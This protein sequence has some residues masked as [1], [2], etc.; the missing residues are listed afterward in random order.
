MLLFNGSLVNSLDGEGNTALHTA[1]SMDCPCLTKLLLDHGADPEV[2]SQLGVKARSL[3]G[4]NTAS[5][6]EERPLSAEKLSTE[7]AFLEASK[8]VQKT[9][10]FIHLIRDYSRLYIHGTLT[11]YSILSLVRTRSIRNSG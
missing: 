7:K 11:N 2:T 8:V 10:V 6:L 5:L 1:L 3:A 4:T 9:H